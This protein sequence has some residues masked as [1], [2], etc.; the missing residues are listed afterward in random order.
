MS[1]ELDD[2]S[3]VEE[4]EGLEEGRPLDVG[5]MDLS[6]EES[7]IEDLRSLSPQHAPVHSLKYLE[8]Q[9]PILPYCGC[10]P[11]HCHLSLNQRSYKEMKI[12][13]VSKRMI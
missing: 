5:A 8:G 6:D 9:V 13:Q 12:D 10:E 2:I 11:V 7:V 3:E 1:L 4:L